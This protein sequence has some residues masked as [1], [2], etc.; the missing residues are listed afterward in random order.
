LAALGDFEG[1]QAGLR[2]AD[3]ALVTQAFQSACR[4]EHRAVAAALLD[5]CIELD[6][7]LGELVDGWRGRSAFVDYLI[8]HP[9]TFGGPWLTVV[10]TEL[11]KAIDEDDLPE[12]TWWVRQE[13]DLLGERH[14]A[15]Q[16]KLIEYAVLND[17]GPA[18]TR[19]LELKPAITRGVTPPSSSAL[20]FAMEYGNA[21]L[22]PLL[23]AI[24]P[25]P[26][27]LPHSEG[28]PKLGSLG[29]HY[30]ANNP[31]I[32]RHLHWT[33]ANAQHVLDVALAWA[34]MNRHFEIAAFLLER[35]ANIDTD[36]S[37]HEPAGILHECAVQGNYEAAQFAIDHGID[38]TRRDYRWNGTAEGWAFY[39]A[40]DKKM[41]EFLA[42]EKARK[43][44]SP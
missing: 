25:L 34:C 6:R 31:T 27:D 13:P 12:F 37:T 22:I 38:M 41:A 39:A 18:L 35:G 23:T 7:T 15:M 20:Q 2:A 32:L 43:P 17:R 9:Q 42:A 33:P 44:A 3:G 26:G 10:M 36:W 29:Q 1:V 8:E 11:L 4:F 28:R 5:R 24:W 19:L 40:N 14:L 16:V 30:P 21:H